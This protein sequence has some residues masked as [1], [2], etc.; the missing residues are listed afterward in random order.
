MSNNNVVSQNPNEFVPNPSLPHTDFAGKPIKAETDFFVLPY[1]IGKIISG[2]S[3]LNVNREPL[4][5]KHKSIFFLIPVIITLIILS[6]IFSHILNPN[7]AP[8]FTFFLVL[9]LIVYLIIFLFFKKRILFKYYCNAVGDEGFAEFFCRGSRE[10]ITKSYTVRFDAVTD[11]YVKDNNETGETEVEIEGEGLSFKTKPKFASYKWINRETNKTV[12]KFQSL[13]NHLPFTPPGPRLI[14]N[15]AANKQWA[16][17]LF[18]NMQQILQQKGFLSFNAYNS[19]TG[20]LHP[21]IELSPKYISIIH[22]NKKDTYLFS[23]GIFINIIN[24]TLFIS[25]KNEHK[26]ILTSKTINHEYS[27]ASLCN[28]LF[29]N[30]AVKEVMSFEL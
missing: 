30:K 24:N 6:L 2:H 25:Q 1:G 4:S 13:Y 26:T 8:V 22:G 21:Y 29:F 12:Y 20:K 11:I 3:D 7:V 16:D 5:A 23:E 28:R 19:I 17:F 18:G 10:K 15:R 9:F 14:F 27:L